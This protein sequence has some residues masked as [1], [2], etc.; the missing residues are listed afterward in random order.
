MIVSSEIVANDLQADGRRYITER[1]A[2]SDGSIYDHYY[3]AAIDTDHNA[4]MLARVRQIEVQ[5]AEAEGLQIISDLEDSAQ[6]KED[7]F[8][9]K[10]SDA[11]RKTLLKQTDAEIAAVK[12]KV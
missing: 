3:L 7:D 12:E 9:A 11:D 8:L 4:A 10:M 2:F 6:A 1:H 5:V